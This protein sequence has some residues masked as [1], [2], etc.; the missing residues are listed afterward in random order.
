[1]NRYY[2]HYDEGYDVSGFEE[3]DNEQ[4]ALD[5][6]ME[7]MKNNGEPCLADYDLLY[8]EIVKVVP[9]EVVTA[10]KTERKP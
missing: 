2:V 8:G 6:I 7:R 3:F 10:L 9:V 1:M 5:F 4:Y